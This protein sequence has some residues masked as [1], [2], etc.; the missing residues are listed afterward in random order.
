MAEVLFY[1]LTQ[2]PV[3]VTLPD[4]L[5]KTLARGWRALVR[6]GSDA[7]R[8]RLDARLWLGGDTSFLP[9]GRAGG[10]HDS[11]QPVL[12]TTGAD[13]RNDANILFTL[14]GAVLSTSEA[15]KFTRVCVLFD[16][17]DPERLG[18][19]RTLWSEVSKAGLP[20]KYWAQEGGKWQQKAAVNT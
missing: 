16:G 15:A 17:N 6:C 19:A 1:H 20:T 8:D 18:Q 13:N 5:E 2:A 10:A 12:L 11:D 4:L 7:Q 3:E 9:H 14:D